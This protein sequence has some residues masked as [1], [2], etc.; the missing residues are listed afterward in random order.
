MIF[1]YNACWRYFILSAMYN[2]N[3]SMELSTTYS[4]R[5]N[6]CCPLCLGFKSYDDKVKFN[7]GDFLQFLSPAT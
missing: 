2:I 4:V 5:Y 1:Q 6:F 3:S 7:S